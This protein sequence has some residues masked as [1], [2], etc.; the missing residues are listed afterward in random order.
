MAVLS[1]ITTPLRTDPG[2]LGYYFGYRIAQAYYNRAT[3]KKQAVV[4]IIEMDDPLLFLQ[5]SGYDP[6]PKEE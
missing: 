6:R 2:D 1:C 5:K 4:D 3:D